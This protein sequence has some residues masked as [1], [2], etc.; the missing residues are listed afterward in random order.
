MGGPDGR[1]ASITLWAGAE[2]STLRGPVTKITPPDRAPAGVALVVA[3]VAAD[4]PVECRGLH[5]GLDAEQLAVAAVGDVGLTAMP[6]DL[7][8]QALRDPADDVAG[9]HLR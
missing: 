3:V 1:I 4:R 6:A 2:N 7:A 9:P 5:V 8:H